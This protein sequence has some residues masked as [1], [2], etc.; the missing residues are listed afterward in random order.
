[1]KRTAK[2]ISPANFLAKSVVAGQTNTVVHLGSID[3]AKHSM[4]QLIQR[5]TVDEHLQWADECTTV[6]YGITVPGFACWADTLGTI[7]NGYTYRHRELCLCRPDDGRSYAVPMSL[8][9]R[10]FKLPDIELADDELEAYRYIADRISP[11]PKEIT[12]TVNHPAKTAINNNGCKWKDKSLDLSDF[13]NMLN[14]NNEWLTPILIAALDT[15]LRSFSGCD[16]IPVFCYNF[17]L[18]KVN[19]QADSNFIRVL[20]AMNFT[21][22]NGACSAAPREITVQDNGDIEDWNGCHDRL[23]VLR[24]VKGGGLAPIFDKLDTYDRSRAY[25]GVLPPRLSTVPIIRSKTFFDRSDTVDCEL[26][27]VIPA[28]T[29]AQLSCLRTAFSHVLTGENAADASKRWRDRMYHMCGFLRN[30]FEEWR[31]VLFSVFLDSVFPKQGQAKET[32]Q[33]GFQT[34]QKRQKEAEEEREKILQDALD[35]VTDQSRYE[36][37]IIDTPTTPDEG[38]KLL[39]IEQ[40][41]VAF[42]YVRKHKN[43]DV[44]HYI[45]FTDFSLLR[46]LKRVDLTEELYGPFKKRALKAGV[47]IM[48][49]A[50]ARLH[51]QSLSGHYWIRYADDPSDL[52]HASLMQEMSKAVKTV[53][54]NN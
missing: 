21:V 53:S 2:S 38:R 17:T 28:L 44:N 35:L 52:S 11:K 24:T 40:S 39:N 48:K 25:K 31:D 8:A 3:L 32:A 43:G 12:S 51:S 33:T 36:D 30:P 19:L 41:A 18:K 5:L 54:D 9:E 46:L 13:S 45:V 10:K 15:Q 20:T 49:S 1:M 14:E 27:E 42:R 6:P 47:M 4:R 23:V 16:G 50:C 7:V 26:P 37:E 29:D 34:A 22:Q